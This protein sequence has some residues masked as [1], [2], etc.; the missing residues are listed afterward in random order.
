MQ[1]IINL[2]ISPRL[3][4]GLLK[5]LVHLSKQMIPQVIIV[6]KLAFTIKFFSS[7]LDMYFL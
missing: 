2:E 7:L 3:H 1:Q 6:L 5:H 4:T